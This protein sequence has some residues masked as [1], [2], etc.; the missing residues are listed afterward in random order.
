MVA[1]TGKRAIPIDQTGARTDPGM[2]DANIGG[3]AYGDS[4][5][6]CRQVNDDETWPHM[7][8]RAT[9]QRFANCGVGNYGLDQALLRY[10]REASLRGGRIAIM[11]VVPETICRVQSFWKHFSEYGNIFAFKPRF[12]VMEEGELALLP[13]AIRKQEDFFRI[14]ELL[15][16]LMK[17]DEFTA[18]KFNQDMLRAPY[19]LHTL[20]TWR[21]TL[22]LVLAAAADCIAGG[23]ERAF[24]EVMKRNTA[25]TAGQYRNE[26]ATALLAAIVRRFAETARSN[27]ATPMLVFI[28][29]LL[30]LQYLR[31]GNHFYLDFLEGLREDLRTVD[32]GPTL[33]EQGDDKA[34]YIED[35][36]GGHLSTLGNSIVCDALLP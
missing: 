14:D 9:G 6:F 23:G 15:P 5:T 25:I 21:R 28:P 29:Q 22:P 19:L 3:V 33:L 12:R 35:R 31:G 34:I 10:E 18:A 20:R 16:A 27:G 7:L 8:S 13:N 1:T 11:G 24:F 32:M 4:Y 36:F 2:D 17:N 30:D 26:K